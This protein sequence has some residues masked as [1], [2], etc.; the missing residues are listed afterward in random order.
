MTEHGPP[1]PPPEAVLVRRARLARGLSTAQA[2]SQAT[3]RLGASRW[4]QI[5]RGYKNPGEPLRAPADTLAHMAHIV[6]LTPDRLEEAGRDDAADILREILRQQPA[7]PPYAN[8][9]DP[10]ERV[11]WEMALPEDVRRDLI[12]ALR[13][14][15]RQR[16]LPHRQGN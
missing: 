5:E 15:K 8:L 16:E 14:S 6:G 11:L 2:A 9:T 1:T 13:A 12:D 10:H 4:G 7:P 3:T